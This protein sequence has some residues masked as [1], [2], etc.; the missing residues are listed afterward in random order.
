MVLARVRGND[1]GS[2]TVEFV[3]VA[4]PF[5]LIVLFVVE[6]TLAFFWWKS[7]EKATMLGARLA[8]V[9]DVA[10]AGVPLIN[11]KAAN[12][13]YGKGC[14]NLDGT[15]SGQCQDALGTNWSCGVD[16][17]NCIATAK[18]NIVAK[19]RTIL[20]AIQPE[21]VQITYRN[22]GLGYAGGP[23]IP[24]VTVTLTGLQFQTGILSI[25]GGVL[26]G[27]SLTSLPDISATMTGE[28]LS[29]AAAGA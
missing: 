7:A 5:F 6:V 25:I 22:V 3:A 28:D 26:G 15:A 27:P 19:M 18:A 8:I 17:S 21:N 24:E 29:S 23:M 9:Q 14:L 12:G 4:L 16:G 11:A 1:A 10:A 20:A 2:A 13:I